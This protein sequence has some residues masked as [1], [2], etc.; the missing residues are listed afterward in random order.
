M[1]EKCLNL[2]LF[3]RLMRC[4]VALTNVRGGKEVGGDRGRGSPSGLAGWYHEVDPHHSN[5][6]PLPRDTTD[7]TN[8][9]VD[10]FL[11]FWFRCMLFWNVAL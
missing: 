10:F 8:R 6:H 2:R 1:Q 7:L 3:E 5:A 11:L 4:V 9:I